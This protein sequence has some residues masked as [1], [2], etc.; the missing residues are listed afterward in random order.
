MDKKQILFSRG[1]NF[2]LIVNPH[3]IWENRFFDI[4][5][6]IF[7]KYFW[8][9]FDLQCRNIDGFLKNLDNFQSQLA[10]FTDINNINYA[11]CSEL[12]NE[13]KKEFDLY[14]KIYIAKNPYYSLADK[15]LIDKIND[16]N[17]IINSSDFLN[18]IKS[19][20]CNTFTNSYYTHSKENECLIDYSIF[21]ESLKQDMIN[22][23]RI[24]RKF[25]DVKIFLQEFNMLKDEDQIVLNRIKN[26]TN[27]TLKDLIEK[28][29]DMS[30]SGNIIFYKKL[31]TQEIVEYLKP[32]FDIDFLNY[33]YCFDI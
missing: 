13:N 30:K 33:R 5:C 28:T 18:Y 9:Y 17:D 7:Y 24:Y 20:N 6:P 8:V 22:F 19:I 4:I 16:N 1:S 12:L 26:N 31:Y 29:G 23:Y 15:Y 27:I 3:A 25:K 10:H 21:P 11:T 32:Y 14:P 2:L